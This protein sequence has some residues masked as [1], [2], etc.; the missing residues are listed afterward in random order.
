MIIDI[1]TLDQLQW[2]LADQTFHQFYDIDTKLDLHLITIGFR[3]AFATDVI[4]EQW[5][6]APPDTWFCPFLEFAYVPIV[7]T[8]FTE[9]AVLFLD[10]SPWISLGTFS[11]INL[12]IISVFIYNSNMTWF[13]SLLS[14]QTQA[15]YIYPIWKLPQDYCRIEFSRYNGLFSSTK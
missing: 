10:I 2:F 6:L 9:I 15:V 14:Q 1:L 11:H 13:F 7:E 3:E 12:K 5:T 4:R 8:C